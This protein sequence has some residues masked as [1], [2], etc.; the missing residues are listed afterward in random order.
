MG[1]H[2][3]CWIVVVI[4]RE[5]HDSTSWIGTRHTYILCNR[6]E[7]KKILLDLML[8]VLVTS[9]WSNITGSTEVENRDARNLQLTVK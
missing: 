8:K 4:R 6:F 2:D 3:M 9:F 5:K 7:K 1:T